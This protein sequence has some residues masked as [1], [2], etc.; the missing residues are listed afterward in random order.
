M[1]D[2]HAAFGEE[3]FDVAV[4]EP[5]PQ[6]PVDRELDDLGREPV[7]GERR[8]LDYDRTT[9]DEGISRRQPHPKPSTTAN[10]TVPL[11]VVSLLMAVPSLRW[12]RV[13]RFG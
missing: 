3:C 12:S 2:G 1:I 11:S 8:P 10:A 5:E 13:R 6:V 7:A 9:V 4:G